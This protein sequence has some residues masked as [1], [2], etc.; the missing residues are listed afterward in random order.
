M[1]S[2][3]PWAIASSRQG[4]LASYFLSHFLSCFSLRARACGPLRRKD[5]LAPV[6]HGWAVA[7][8][9]MSIGSTL[10][11]GTQ[12]WHTQQ[13][14]LIVEGDPR[15][16]GELSRERGRSCV[17]RGLLTTTSGG[18]GQETRAIRSRRPTR[19]P[20]RGQR[21]RLGQETEPS[22]AF[23]RLRVRPEGACATASKEESRTESKMGSEISTKQF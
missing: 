10:L 1:I 23:R 18:P 19:S 3:Q 4:G 7:Q 11:R 6:C 9:C 2:N 16:D 20:D 15:D 14:F 21:R 22:S 5:P 17:R 13:A 12:Q 8:P